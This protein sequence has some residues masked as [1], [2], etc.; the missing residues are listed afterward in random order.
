MAIWDENF[1]FTRCCCHFTSHWASVS[2]CP[3]F[4]V[5]FKHPVCQMN[6]RLVELIVRFRV[7][8]IPDSIVCMISDWFHA[9]SVVFSFGN[10]KTV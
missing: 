3:R 7:E 10:T 6:G 4:T 2:V 9:T 1:H 8:L 5:S